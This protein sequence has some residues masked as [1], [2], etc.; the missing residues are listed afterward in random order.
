MKI[1]AIIPARGGSKGVPRKNIVNIN[2]MPLIGYTINAALKSNKLT[3]VVVSTDDAEIAEISRDLGAQVP[4]IRPIDLASDQAQS[5]PVIEH[6]VHFMENIKGFKY[7]AVLMLQPTSP[8]RT[9]KHINESLDLFT[10][11]DCDS[12][13]SIV[14]VGGN[15]PFRM[16][17]LIGDQLINYIDQGFWDMRPRQSL[18]DVYIRNGAIYLIKRNVFMQN[19]QLIGDRC[20][21]YIMND[22]ES[23]NI[24]TPI[25]LKIAE[26]LLK[27]KL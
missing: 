8:L 24:D 10:S 21:G 3:D 20:L 5:S 23:T 2:N 1:L 13:V 16:K 26:L 17:R 22:Y 6:A 15:H 9:S 27:E 11:Q 4:F 25:D 12:V 19:Q 14:S 18:P 7:D